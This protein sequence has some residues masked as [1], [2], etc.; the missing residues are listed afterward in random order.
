MCKILSDVFIILLESIGIPFVQQLLE[1]TFIN[2]VNCS[3]SVVMTFF[4]CRK[5]SEED[6]ISCGDLFTGGRS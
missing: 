4:S 1:K 5:L 6:E 2:I 3:N